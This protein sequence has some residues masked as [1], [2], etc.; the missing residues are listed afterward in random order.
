M[1]KV[2]AISHAVCNHHALRRAFNQGGWGAWHLIG[3][4]S[5]GRFMPQVG[6]RQLAKRPAVPVQVDVLVEDPR[7]P[8]RTCDVFAFHASPRRG[9][10]VCKRGTHLLGAP[11]DGDALHVLLVEPIEVGRGG[12]CGVEEEFLRH[13]AC[14]LL[15]IGDKLEHLVMVLLCAQ[16]PIGVAQNAGLSI[17][18]QKGQEPLLASTALGDRVLL[19]QGI[20]A[21]Q[22]HG[23][24][25]A[26]EGGPLLQAPC[27]AGIVPY[28]HEGGRAS[29]VKTTTL[30]GQKGALG[31]DVEPSTQRQACVEDRAHAMAMAGMAKE[32]QGEEGAHRLR[33]G[34]FP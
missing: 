6:H 34:D 23:M 27:A 21:M 20:L 32:F 11:P 19:D 17:M 2:D 13:L 31:Q 28:A 9:R 29:G 26:S 16:W 8:V 5:R 1:E 14:P 33:S 30:L 4:Q 12:Q 24:A 10:H 18:R 3:Q 25:V 22:R 15:P 7:T